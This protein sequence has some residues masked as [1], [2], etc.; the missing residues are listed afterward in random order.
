ML[1]DEVVTAFLLLTRLN[2][3]FKR[4][5]KPIFCGCDFAHRIDGN[6]TIRGYKFPAFGCLISLLGLMQT[7][8]R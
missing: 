2:E 1:K 3:F 6:R 8:Q 7:T 4:G 5:N